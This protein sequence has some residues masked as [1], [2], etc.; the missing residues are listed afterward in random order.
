M[1]KKTLEQE[2][3]FYRQDG[4]VGLYYS[5]NKKLNEFSRAIDSSTIDFSSRDDKCSLR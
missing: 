3:E 5:L 2:L 1:A 4:I